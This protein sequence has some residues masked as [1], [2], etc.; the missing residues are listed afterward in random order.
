MR[1]MIWLLWCRWTKHWPFGCYE[2]T[3]RKGDKRI[4]FRWCSACHR[5]YE[6]DASAALDAI[7]RSLGEEGGLQQQEEG[8]E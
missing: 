1:F 3:M 8:R 5:V 2:T 6:P 4:T 7:E